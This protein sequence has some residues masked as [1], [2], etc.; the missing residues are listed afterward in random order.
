ML[1]HRNATAIQHTID[2]SREDYVLLE[3][4]PKRKDDKSLFV[5][6][7][8]SS[9]KDKGLGLPDL[10]IK[11]QRLA[12]R[13]QLIVV[14]DFNAPHPE[15]GYIRATPKGNRL[16]RVAQDLQ[17]TT[18]NNPLDHTRIGNS[19]ST[20]SS[21]D[22]TFVKG[23]RDAKWVNTGQPLGSD[24]YILSTVFSAAKHKDRV[25][26]TRVTDWDRFRK[27]RKDTVSGEIEDLGA[28]VEA[29]KQDVKGTTEEVPTV[30]EGFT[31]DSRLLHMWEAHASLLRRW[32]KQKHNGVLRRKVAKL[33]REIETYTLD[34]Q[35]KQW[36]RFVTG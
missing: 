25:K 33:E 10:L 19:V 35:C 34:L 1:V 11:T 15:W 2:S 23:I 17:W 6:N 9:P 8:Y 16:W 22:L 31:A 20:D 30:E 26:G 29:L 4:L 28:W 18:L 24:H 7:V 36:G 3:V 27:V 14:G 12:A 32:K 5:L 21:P 13:A